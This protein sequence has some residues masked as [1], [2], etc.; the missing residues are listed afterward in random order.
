MLLKKTQKRRYQKIPLPIKSR[1][2]RTTS[3]LFG[4]VAYA[5]TISGLGSVRK[6]GAVWRDGELL[7]DWDI[8]GGDIESPQGTR[9]KSIYPA[10]FYAVI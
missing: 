8:G 2:R 5:R 7:S 4:E 10:R 9:S 1:C 3:G 6:T